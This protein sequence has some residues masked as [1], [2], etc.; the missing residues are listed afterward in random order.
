MAEYHSI[1]TKCSGTG[2]VPDLYF[3]RKR[4]LSPAWPKGGI[5]TQALQHGII[6]A[7]QF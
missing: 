6:S 7:L 4:T 1:R 2:L 5:W 3:L